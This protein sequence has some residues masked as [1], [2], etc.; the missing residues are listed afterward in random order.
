M[1]ALPANQ[2]LPPVTVG[3]LVFR[4]F[5]KLVKAFGM[6]AGAVERRHVCR[7]HFV[8]SQLPTAVLRP[9]QTQAELLAEDQILYSAQ[10]S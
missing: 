10:C 6:H 1:P 4:Y 5:L 7:P 8:C 3:D 9:K 2:N